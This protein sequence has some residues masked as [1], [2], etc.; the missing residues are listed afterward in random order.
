MP[1]PLATPLVDNKASMEENL[2]RIV[3]STCEQNEQMSKRMSELERAVRVERES[4][5]QEIKRNRLEVAN[6]ANDAGDAGT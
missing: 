3:H 2:T 6:D 1:P 5:W 4:L